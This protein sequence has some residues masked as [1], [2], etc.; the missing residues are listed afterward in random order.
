MVVGSGDAEVVRGREEREGEWGTQGGWLAIFLCLAIKG[1]KI[2]TRPEHASLYESTFSVSL[3]VVA[4]FL[5]LLFQP[6][7][8]H[9]LPPQ[10]SSLL[11]AS[12]STKNHE[13]NRA[14]TGRAVR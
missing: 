12:T 13:G 5:A 1:Y 7:Q 4:F 3:S 2:Q 8:H 6:N 14:R 11:F 10:P 9:Y